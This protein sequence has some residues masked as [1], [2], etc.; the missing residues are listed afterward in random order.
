M[1]LSRLWTGGEQNVRSVRRPTCSMS[2]PFS[3]MVRQ[4]TKIIFPVCILAWGA[5]WLQG[6]FIY[7][8]YTDEKKLPKEI[9]AILFTTGFVAG[10]V[11]AL[12]VG[13]LGGQI[14]SKE[15]MFGF[16]CYYQFRISLGE[17]RRLL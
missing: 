13:S 7:I 2:H 6:P 14:W 3:R 4:F 9:V 1:I 10:A 8:L 17:H 11:P 15:R 12:F 5:D 16:V